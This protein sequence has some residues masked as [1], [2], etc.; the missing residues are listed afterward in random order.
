LIFSILSV[1]FE[2]LF[3]VADVLAFEFELLGAGFAP[4]AFVKEYVFVFTAGLNSQS[5]ISNNPSK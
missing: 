5:Q 2:V 3:L 4:Q 1:G